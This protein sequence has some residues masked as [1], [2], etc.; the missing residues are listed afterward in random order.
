M[1]NRITIS[2]QIEVLKRLEQEI[3]KAGVP[4]STYIND[5]F[6]K[7]FNIEKIDR[8]KGKK[9]KLKGGREE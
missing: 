7:K 5:E 8:R 3:K 4:F 2:F 6:R 1:E 9:K